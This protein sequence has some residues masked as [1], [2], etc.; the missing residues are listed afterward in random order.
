MKNGLKE[1]IIFYA[2]VLKIPDN[3]KRCR[4]YE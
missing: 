1:G 3:E 2:N 4:S